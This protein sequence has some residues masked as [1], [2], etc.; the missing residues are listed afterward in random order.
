[1]ALGARTLREKRRK[2]KHYPSEFF[3]Q[4]LINYTQ[5]KSRKVESV[6]KASITNKRTNVILITKRNIYNEDET[7][8]TNSTEHHPLANIWEGV[9]CAQTCLKKNIETCFLFYVTGMFLLRDAVVSF[10]ADHQQKMG[11]EKTMN[12]KKNNISNIS[13]SRSLHIIVHNHW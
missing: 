10:E 4:H 12:Y 5:R 3:T 13:L 8:P 6:I 1:M 7:H 11:E 9:S 2:I